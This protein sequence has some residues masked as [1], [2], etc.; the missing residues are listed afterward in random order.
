MQCFLDLALPIQKKYLDLPGQDSPWQTTETSPEGQVVSLQLSAEN[1]PLP[2]STFLVWGLGYTG[3]G[4][5]RP[6]LRLPGM[7][8]KQLLPLAYCSLPEGNWDMTV[9]RKLM[10]VICI[11]WGL[12]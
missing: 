3:G 11:P 12:S 2:L 4:R 10:K 5:E 1:A 6:E 7:Q 8:I 9:S